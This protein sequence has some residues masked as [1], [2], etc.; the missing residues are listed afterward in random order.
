MYRPEP[1]DDGVSIMKRATLLGVACAVGLGSAAIS[2][3]H[4]DP[5]EGFGTNIPLSF[6]VRQIVPTGYLV[7]FD[8]GI[9]QSSRVSWSGGAEWRE[10][11]ENLAR[12]KRL[13]VS[14][15]GQLVRLSPSGGAVHAT[16]A[17][18]SEGSRR[19]GGLLMVPYRSPADIAVAAA[20]QPLPEPPPA[21]VSVAS[22]PPPPP[23]APPPQV[24]EAPAPAPEMTPAQAPAPRGRRAAAQA[25]QQPAPQQVRAPITGSATWRAQQGETL[26]Q[27]MSDW[28]ERAGWTLVFQSRLI[29]EL[30]AS[31]DFEGDFVQ[32]AATLIR[33]VRARPMPIATFYSGNRV[34]VISNSADGAN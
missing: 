12:A 4:A 21:A 8:G 34:L 1:H 16:A 9:D 24:A 32:A 20:P 17:P 22:L 18:A 10:V 6:A 33:S 5:L 30:Q 25:A 7:N 15:Q 23:P 27:V 31:A 3:A 29:Y 14:Y 2:A 11:L 28:A 13:S 19:V 26:D